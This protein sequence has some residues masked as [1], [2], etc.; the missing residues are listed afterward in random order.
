MTFI[1]Q[2]NCFCPVGAA[3]LEGFVTCL[4]IDCKQI[5]KMCLPNKSPLYA[6]TSRPITIRYQDT[7]SRLYVI[8]TWT[9]LS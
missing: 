5:L 8:P 6:V 7:L 9:K 3:D 1:N 4:I 2:R